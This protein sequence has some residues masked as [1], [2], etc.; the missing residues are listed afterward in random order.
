MVPNWIWT[1]GNPADDRGTK[2]PVNI[3]VKNVPDSVVQRL[4]ARARRRH[5]S[6]QGELLTILEEAAGQEKFTVAQL[7]EW[8]R[9]SGLRT[10]SEAVEM[11]REDRDAR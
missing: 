4:R 3:S 9:E 6:L 7:S 11:I 2:M 1:D 5:R 10:D 8:V